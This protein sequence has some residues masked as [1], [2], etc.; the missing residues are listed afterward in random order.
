VS[1][2]V[3]ERAFLS[4]G[5]VL[6]LLKD[7]FPDVTISKIRFLES[8]GLIDPERTPS[9]YRKFYEPDVARLRWILEQ[10]RD[11]FLPLKV[12]KD[13]ILANPGPELTSSGPAEA[14]EPAP[15]PAAPPAP[16]REQDPLPVRP[17]VTQSSLLP[18]LSSVSLTI[19]EL[20]T[21]SGLPVSAIQELER[22]TLLK[23]RSV[24]GQVYYDEEALVVA[25]LAASMARH[26]VEARHLRMYKTAAE[27]EAAFYEQVI[28]PFMKQ[29]NPT[30]RRQAV[31]TL[32]EL[33]KLGE[34]MRAAFVRASLRDYTEG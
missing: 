14:S 22:Y 12:I 2:S 5:E 30:A 28:A 6:E 1:D 19:G 8:Q 21:S 10:Q 16:A 31:E 24:G 34:S 7:E 13:K 20:S 3:T 23:G 9:G 25:S 33:T 4:I 18:G 29:R 27:R 15:E 11:H 26:G 17:A 32:E